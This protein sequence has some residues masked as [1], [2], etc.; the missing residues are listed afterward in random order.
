ML[1]Y[2]LENTE[3]GAR[4]FYREGW[5]E[6]MQVCAW[7]RWEGVPLRLMVLF[8]GEERVACWNC[9]A[10]GSREDTAEGICCC[11]TCAR[12]AEERANG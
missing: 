12:H 9:G 7:P 4:A 2:W 1:T 8:D 5:A 10:I 6:M 3:T 11:E